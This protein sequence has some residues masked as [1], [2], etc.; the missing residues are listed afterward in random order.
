MPTAIATPLNIPAS[1][2][3]PL[4]SIILSTRN[5]LYSSSLATR[6]SSH[7]ITAPKVVATYGLQVI[8]QVLPAICP[9]R[10]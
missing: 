1:T 6:A 10:L 2:R 3:L 4:R 8:P 7:P 9:S 5:A